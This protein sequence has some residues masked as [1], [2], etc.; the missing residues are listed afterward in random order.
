MGDS[1]RK[2]EK[3]EEIVQKP[4]SNHLNECMEHFT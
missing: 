3:K 1:H 2:I 4:A